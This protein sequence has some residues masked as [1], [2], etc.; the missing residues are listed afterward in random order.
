MAENR[1]NSKY[2]FGHMREI[3]VVMKKIVNVRVGL[4]RKLGKE[5][6]HLMP[7]LVLV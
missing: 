2:E 4:K 1:N 7:L 5:G 3:G 6:R